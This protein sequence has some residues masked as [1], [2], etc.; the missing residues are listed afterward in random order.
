MSNLRK[1]L[2][3]F[4]LLFGYIYCQNVLNINL[5]SNQYNITYET[6]HGCDLLSST[7]V[8]NNV[9]CF[10]LCQQVHCKWF[11]F[12]DQSSGSGPGNPDQSNCT[13]YNPQIDLIQYD[14]YSSIQGLYLTYALGTVQY[15]FD[16]IF[17]KAVY[18]L[19]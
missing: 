15:Y 1:I 19:Y 11:Q 16:M 9:K 4:S 2:S 12:D 7:I 6:S 10:I 5:N 13:I 8:S 3:T 18:I 17:F 14:Q